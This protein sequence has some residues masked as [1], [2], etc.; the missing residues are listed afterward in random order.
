[1]ESEE[2]RKQLVELIMT[3]ALK[4][5]PALKKSF[6][7]PIKWAGESL[8]YKGKA[9]IVVTDK[10]GGSCLLAIEVKRRVS[11]QDYPQAILAAAC[12]SRMRKGQGKIT[13]CYAVLTDGLS[14]I[15]FCIL[16]NRTVIMSKILQI[17]L[18]GEVT[19]VNDVL[20]AFSAVLENIEIHSPSSRPKPHPPNGPIP[21]SDMRNN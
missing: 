1:M 14:Y 21:I 2:A 11:V 9:D 12:L 18:E 10:F 3:E 13:P 7:Y 8:R 4:S 19:G 20:S 17:G 16:P 6:E 15:W 5:Y